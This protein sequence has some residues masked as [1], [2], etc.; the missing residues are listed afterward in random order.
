MLGGRAADLWGRRRIFLTGL[1]LFTVCSLIGGLAQSGAWLI[2]ARAGQGIGGAILAPASLSLLTTRFT[3]PY[4]RRKALGA[5]PITSA[6]GAALGVLAG[7]ILTDLLNWRWVLFVNVPIGAA[8]VALT[9]LALAESRL[10]GARPRLDVLGALTVSSGLAVL[11]YGIVGTTSH[12][13]GSA[14]TLTT[15][16]VGV[17]LLTAFAITEIYFARSP[18]VP[19]SVFKRRSLA[20]VNAVTVSIGAANF[21]AYYFLS[22]YL[23]QVEKYSPCRPDWI[24]CPWASAPS[25]AHRSAPDWW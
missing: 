4:E 3:D 9:L 10:D 6:S 21:G 23:Q 17:A 8:V 18:L 15:L 25:P 22:L 1:A 12:P 14:R 19:F 13:W 2:T 5:W 7:G 16:A 20:V 11:V 24:S